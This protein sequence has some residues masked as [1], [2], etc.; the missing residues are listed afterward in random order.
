MN[1]HDK[2]SLIFRTEVSKNG[3][4]VKYAKYEPFS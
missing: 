1:Y 4:A 2:K 3:L